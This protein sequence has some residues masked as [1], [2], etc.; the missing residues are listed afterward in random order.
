MSRITRRDFL[1]GALLAAG[2][3]LI[4]PMAMGN[5]FLSLIDPEYYPPAK[6]GMRGS[7]QGSY[8]HAHAKAWGA[9]SDWGNVTHDDDEYDL[10]IVGAGAS[11]LAA[12]HFY[13]KAHG[14]D[15]K[16]LIL[17]NHDDFGGHAR[18][19]EHHIDG[20]MVLANGG[21]QTLQSPSDYGKSTLELMD[22]IGVKFDKFY[23]YFDQNFY[24]KNNLYNVTYFDKANY[25][26]DKVVNYAI[27]GYGDSM[28]RKDQKIITIDEAVKE[29]PLDGQVKEELTRILKGEYKNDKVS[30]TKEHVEYLSSTPY[31]E[32]LKN[33]YNA[34]HPE[35]QKMMRWI[36][37]DYMSSGADCFSAMEA[38]Y[39]LIPGMTDEQMKKILGKKIAEDYL[40]G[41]GESYIHHFPDGNSSIPRMLVRKLIPNA[42]EGNTME[43]IVT[44]KMKYDQLDK[45]SNNV[46]I[47]LNSTVINA[48]HD[49]AVSTAEKVK[50]QYINNGK[51]YEVKGRNVI[52][53]CY[54]MMIPHLI[55]DLPKE[56]AAS[57]KSLVKSPLVYTTVGMRNWKALK[58]KQIGSAVSPA[59]WHT[60]SYLDF[61]VSMGDYK[62]GSTPDQ[63][64][65]FNMVYL[66]GG[67]EYGGSAVD[68][69]KA[70][71]Y[72][73]LGTT[74]DQFES[75]IKEHLGGML[76]DAGFDPNRDIASI[77]VNRWS[78]GYNYPGGDLD[79]VNGYRAAKI[80]RQKF[81][82]IAIA[83]S[84]SVCVSYIYA[85][86]DQAKRAVEELN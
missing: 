27:G 15:K 70:G 53:A 77:T 11:G 34:S 30:S 80:G 36:G 32:V 9:K 47:R 41:D 66:P 25:G 71:R 54:N 7:H 38:F 58:E 12:A 29:M 55:P 51:A 82:R 43:D 83:N 68:H 5:E 59:R 37:S 72:K 40:G 1:N 16:I 75:E 78:H 49:G 79:D 62:H 26:E 2:A 63:P 20:K 84:D 86:I 56:Q 52:M 46:R 10:I 18:R 48:T 24:E 61:P 44:S 8:T 81:G 35:I 50:I 74:F 65:I 13:Q 17:D 21:S 33:N 19:N 57:L 60:Q 4:P 73:L 31:F 23:H 6:T 69:F 3:T 64:A 39:A 14:T 42:A 67:D 28:T 85:A 76:G 22:D 45:K